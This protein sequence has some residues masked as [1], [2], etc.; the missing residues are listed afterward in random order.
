MQIFK[1]LILS[2]IIAPH[3]DLNPDISKTHLPILSLSVRELELN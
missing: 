3:N 1:F 2:V